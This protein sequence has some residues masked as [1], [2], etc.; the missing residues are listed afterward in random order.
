MIQ[1]PDNGKL[2]QLLEYLKL[3]RGFDFTGYKRTT[4]QRRIQKRM[5]E[6]AIE[7]FDDYTDYLQVH[8]EEF[9][10]LFNTILINVTTFFRDPKAW[11]YIREVIIPQ[12]I[13]GAQRSAPIR[14]W[15]AG[16]ASGEEAYSL[17]MLFAE[18]LGFDEFSNRVKIYATDVDEEALAQARNAKYQKEYLEAVKPELLNKYFTEE[19]EVFSFRKDVR[20]QVIFGRH[21]LVQDAPISR[22]NLLVCRNTLMYLNAETQSRILNRFH[23]ALREDGFLFLGKAEMMLSRTNLFQPTELNFRVFSKA[24]RVF[25]HFRN[26][27]TRRSRLKD[28]DEPLSNQMQLWE[29]AFD[30]IQ[31]A[32]IVIDR[33]GTLMMAN[34]EVRSM[35]GIDL[36]DIGRPLQDLEL[37]HRPVDLRSMIDRAFETNTAETTRNIERPIIGGG[38][39]YLDIEV[40]PLPIASDD[41]VGAGIT[42]NDVTRFQEMRVDLERTNQDLETTNEEL[43]SSNEELETTNEELQSTN[44]ELETTNEELQSTNEELETMNEELQSTNEE[45]ETLNTELNQ[46]TEALNI[47]NAFLNSIMDSLETGIAVVNNDMEVISWNNNATEIWGLRHDEV[48]GKVIW[49]L[50]FGL[51]VEKLKKPI[52]SCLTGKCKH[53][54]LT[55]SVIN[56]L[57]QSIE[58]QVNLMPLLTENSVVI[59]VVIMMK[60]ERDEGT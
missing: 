32:A 31:L 28:T 26:D 16:C 30:A 58:C 49:G 42:F 24:P 48:R 45:L 5:H 37:S 54:Q 7:N 53:D 39:Q 43:Q 36:R 1:D 6:V 8:P 59:G 2:E 33:E 18:A 44:E 38:A 25:E 14:V 34:K 12:I 47:S 10:E 20:R 22:L 50:D 11:N 46:R 29:G 13:N 21:N 41:P 17:A 27:Y 15:S 52:K 9:D 4:L 55:L 23:F 57:G 40:V 35:F 51:P 19:S 3:Q 60:A 56:R